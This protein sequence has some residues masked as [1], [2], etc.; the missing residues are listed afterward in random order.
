MNNLDKRIID[1]IKK[2]HVLTLSTS[3]D[4][5]PYTAHCF[6]AYDEKEN[7]LIFTSDFQTKHIKDII[8]NNYVAVGIA[9][10]T[11]KVGIIQGLQINGYAYEAMGENY[12]KFREIYLRRFP[13][14]ILTDKPLWYI[15]ITF[16]KYTD[17]R[18]GFGKKIIWKK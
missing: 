17:N 4:N 14:A 16:L 7:I 8:E 12:E 15:E 9:L 5:K 10:E 3:I 11:W 18:L 1:F 6:Y 2:H 13:F